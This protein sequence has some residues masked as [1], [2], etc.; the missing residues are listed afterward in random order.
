LK[1]D[2][3][4]VGWGWNDYGQVTIPT[5]LSGV[6]AI[7][8]GGLH[9]LALKNDGT[10]VG[11]GWNDYGQVTIPTGLSGVTAIAGGGYHSLALKGD[12][13]VVGWGLN[14]NGQTTIPTGLSGVTA[15]AAGN[16]HSLAL[17]PPPATP[18]PT[19]THTPT[20][21][22]TMTRTPGPTGTPTP[23]VNPQTSGTLNGSVLLQGVGPTPSAAWQVPLVVTFSDVISGNLILTSYPAT[24]STGR[25]SVF[26]IL[27]GTYDVT[28][29]QSGAL[30]RKATGVAFNPG[31]VTAKDFGTLI[32]GDVDSNGLVDIVDFSLLRASF[33][34][35]GPLP[36]P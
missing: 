12:G 14:G 19:V 31:A 33:G 2:G 6:T 28:V 24:D 3:T 35:S 5:G 10:V 32:A 4:V 15:I 13:T 22:R 1:N 27:P 21:T 11:W 34:Q 30:A 29:R 26:G 17:V 25:F 18:T 8:A 36:A 7:A 9:S 20:V 23:T 16:A